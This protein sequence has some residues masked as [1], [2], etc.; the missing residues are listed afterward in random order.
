[1]AVSAYVIAAMCGNFDQ[2]STINPAIFES[3]TPVAWDYE[4]S[5]SNPGVGGY[6]LGQ[7][8]NV[9]TPYGRLW[10]LYQYI[11][12]AGKS[13]TDGSAQLDFLI[14]E[15]T[16]YSSNG[17]M[18]YDT[19]TDFLESDSTD[20]RALAAEYMHCWEG[21]FTDNVYARMDAAE[22]Y[23]DYIVAHYQDDPSDYQ[24]IWRQ[25]NTSDDYLSQS[26]RNNNAM[27]VYFKLNGYVPPSPP[28]PDPPDPPIPP[29]P[30]GP[31]DFVVMSAVK[32]KRGA[33]KQAYRKY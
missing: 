20:V 11:S 33:V 32:K 8:T 17:N 6:G 30:S 28:G 18:G 15:N 14:Y 29:G 12:G 13:M 24:W 22:N 3:T 31:I 9:G 2:E 26:E 21:I 5:D 7:W 23:L 25:T 19:L 10:N 4:Y 27:C 1:M 16:W